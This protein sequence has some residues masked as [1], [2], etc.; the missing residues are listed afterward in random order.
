MRKA[1]VE[2]NQIH[3]STVFKYRFEVFVLEYFHFMRL[4]TWIFV[5]FNTDT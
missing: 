2:R 3:S 5:Y 1:V 4:N